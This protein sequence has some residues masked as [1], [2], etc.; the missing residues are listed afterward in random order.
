MKINSVFSNVLQFI[1]FVA[2]MFNLVFSSKSA[3]GLGLGNK[4]TLNIA[5]FEMSS[6]IKSRQL[7]FSHTQQ[8]ASS[9]YSYR[10]CHSIDSDENLINSQ[11][12]LGKS[13]KRLIKV[14]PHVNP[15]TSRYQEPVMLEEAWLENLFEFPYDRS[16]IVDIGCARGSWALKSAQMNPHINYLGLEIR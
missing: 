5:K 1:P 4:S 9:K 3:I 15:L 2:V 14:R 12:I 8:K 10:L 7:L 11:N 13:K 16:M 6:L